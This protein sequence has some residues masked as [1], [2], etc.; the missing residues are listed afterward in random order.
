MNLSNV[1]LFASSV[2]NTTV[3]CSFHTSHG[4]GSNGVIYLL[5]WNILFT[6]VT[7]CNT[8]IVSFKIGR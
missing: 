1:C 7:I 5:Y 2:S 6:I 8:I 4:G 3:W